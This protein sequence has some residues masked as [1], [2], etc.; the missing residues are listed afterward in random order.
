[1]PKIIVIQRRDQLAACLADCQIS[2]RGG[3]GSLRPKNAHAVIASCGSRNNDR[4]LIGR[5]IIH[6]DKFNGV[7]SLRQSRRESPAEKALR[8]IDRDDNRN[9]G[10]LACYVIASVLIRLHFEAPT[11]ATNKRNWRAVL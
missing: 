5:T 11:L 4:R 8:V 7:V 3:A 10:G 9:K 2:G 1:M 6:D